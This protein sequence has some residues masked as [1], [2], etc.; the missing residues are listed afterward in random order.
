MK[1]W[2]V[3]LFLSLIACVKAPAQEP[4]YLLPPAQTVTGPAFIVVTVEARSGLDTN[5][6]AA[7]LAESH[8]AVL[9]AEWPLT[10]IN[11]HCYVFR[12]PAD[13]GMAETL[14]AMAGDQRVRTAQPMNSFTTMS[15]NADAD[16]TALQ[17]NLAALGVAALPDGI[18][19]R[20]VRVGVVDTRADAAHRDLRGRVVE[21]R[22]FVGD[23]G[24]AGGEVHGTAVAGVIAATAGDGVGIAGVAPGAAIVS[25]RACW[26]PRPGAAGRCNTLS[27]ARALNFMINAD[28]D[29]ANLSVG[30]PYDPLLAELIDAALSAGVIVVAATGRTEAPAF[31]A[32][33]AGVIAVAASE[34]GGGFASAPGL[35][36]LSTAPGDGYDFYS[37]SSIAAAHV[38][39]LAALML[40]D[41]LGLSR[42]RVAAAFDLVGAQDVGVCDLFRA[43]SADICAQ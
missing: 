29:I 17:D 6:L 21:A 30:G 35:D 13:A 32:S 1:R 8:G 34:A 4:S 37:G 2:A 9:S 20:G 19:G 24:A 14:A 18:D 28:I 12:V 16:L 42:G 33:E 3:I 10:A 36:V 40:D 41:R 43:A 7:D 23:E 31:P 25:L 15:V 11:A 5:R 27:M 39:G 22:D 38:S 26:E